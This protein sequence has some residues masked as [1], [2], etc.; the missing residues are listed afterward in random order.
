MKKDKAYEIIDKNVKGT[1]K[2]YI[3]S[4]KQG[5][6]IVDDNHGEGPDGGFT[7]GG[8]VGTTVGVL[9]KDLTKKEIKGMNIKKG[10]SLIFDVVKIPLSEGKI[11]DRNYKAI[12]IKKG[13]PK[14]LPPV[15]PK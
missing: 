6:I 15:F 10:Q 8:L 14:M 9:E 12:N 1:V 5:L 11:F 4:E 2:F 3:T 7:K 13:L